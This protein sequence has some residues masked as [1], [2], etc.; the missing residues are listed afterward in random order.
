M[1]EK[2]A[3]SAID[4]IYE[5]LERIKVIEKQIIVLDSNIKLLNNK[6]VRLKVDSS[7]PSISVSQEKETV[8]VPQATVAARPS[9]RAADVEIPKEEMKTVSTKKSKEPERLVIGNI[10]TF[11]RIVNKNQEP[12]P[13]VEINIYSDSNELVRNLKT[14]K[15]GYWECKLPSGKFGVEYLRKNYKPVNMVI[16]LDSSMSNYEVK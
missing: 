15:D 8:K 3:I 9:A 5:I 4:A 16:A 1:E 12:I 13:G 11:G 14:D 6:I 7:E 2:E 10:K